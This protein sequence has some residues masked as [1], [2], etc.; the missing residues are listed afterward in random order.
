MKQKPLSPVL[1]TDLRSC[2]RPALESVPT[3]AG[4]SVRGPPPQGRLF[5]SSALNPS[6][7]T[8]WGSF[9]PRGFQ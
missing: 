6:Q 5:S 2:F 3:A 8:S 9:F 7:Q 4:A 1:L